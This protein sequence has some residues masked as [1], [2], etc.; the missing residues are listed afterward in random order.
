MA[1]VE[2]PAQPEDGPNVAPRR[3]ELANSVDT[4]ADRVKPKNL[5]SEYGPQLAKAGAAIGVFFL[6]LALIRRLRSR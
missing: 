5:L 2:Q 3:A 4:I 6:L 1:T